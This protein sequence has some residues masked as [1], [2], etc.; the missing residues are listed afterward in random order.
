[1]LSAPVI[2]FQKSTS[3]GESDK[4]ND[5]EYGALRLKL[6]MVTDS[7]IQRKIMSIKFRK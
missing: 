3:F 2:H 5:R 7:G 4:Q 1:M 6:F